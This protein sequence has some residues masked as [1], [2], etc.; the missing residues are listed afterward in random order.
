MLRVTIELLPAYGGPRQTLA[1]AEICNTGG[2]D[3]QGDYDARFYGGEAFAEPPE[4]WGPEH[5]LA[6][7]K[8]HGH[9]RRVDSLWRLVGRAIRQTG[10]L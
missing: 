3:E 6:T 8:V 7:A 2:T 4:K 1:V 5:L 10:V 9:R